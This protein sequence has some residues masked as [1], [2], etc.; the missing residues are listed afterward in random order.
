[1]TFNE[2]LLSNAPESD[3][4]REGLLIN[5]DKLPLDRFQ[6]LDEDEGRRGN[7]HPSIPA[8]PWTQHLSGSR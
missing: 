3:Q 5:I 2:I 4:T 7:F 6:S 8:V 1:M